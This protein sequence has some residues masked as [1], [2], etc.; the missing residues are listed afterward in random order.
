MN[1]I[2]LSITVSIVT[3]EEE[4][5]SGFYLNTSPS[6]LQFNETNTQTIKKVTNNTIL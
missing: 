5:A 6:R 3:G 2:Y 4:W 1:V